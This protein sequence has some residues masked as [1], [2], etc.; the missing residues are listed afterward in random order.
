MRGASAANNPV[1]KQGLRNAG[2]HPIAK[3]DLVALTKPQAVT[4]G[5]DSVGTKKEV[6]YTSHRAHN[7]VLFE[8]VEHLYFKEGDHIADVTYGRGVFWKKLKKS[9]YHC[10]WSDKVT[11]EFYP[12]VK[13]IDFRN[14]PYEN[15][16]MDVVIFDPPYHHTGN[17]KR[18]SE[19]DYRNAETTPNHTH[20][21]IFDLYKVGMME[22][23]RVL[24]PGG[25]LLVKCA[26]EIESGKQRRLHIEVFQYAIADLNLLDQDLFQLTQLRPPR[27]W[28]KTQHHAHNNLSYLWVFQKR[29]RVSA[30]KAPKG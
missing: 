20:A 2:I 7:D 11:H 28:H 27:R 16:C 17:N 12:G 8:K 1:L 18:Q 5:K 26:D 24:K 6:I 19:K 29:R 15:D 30:K 22:A 21:M 13:N 3:P 23:V 14:L 4:T 9:H 25:L 10:Y